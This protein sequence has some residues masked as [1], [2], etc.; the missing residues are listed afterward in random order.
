MNAWF[1]KK[2][3]TPFAA[4]LIA[5][6]CIAASVG[7]TF[8]ALRRPAVGAGEPTAQELYELAVQDAVF[9]DEEEILP[10]VEVVRD[11]DKVT[12]NEAGDRILLLSWH[13]YPDSYPAG[14]EVAFQW[15]EVWAFTDREIVRRYKEEKNSVTDWTLRLEQ[16]IG[17]PPEKGYTHFSAFWVDPADVIR[18]AYVTDITGQMKNTFDAEPSGDAFSKWYGEW[19]DGNIVWSYFDSAYPWTRL[20]YTYDWADNGTEYGLSEFLIL[21]NSK[22]TV[23]FTLSNED[24]L[25]WLGE[26]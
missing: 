26:Q 20:G 15:G 9:A 7:G 23:A 16:L 1:K 14:E 5:L 2:T 3:L 18:P 11:S 4:A 13:R 21:P 19:Y 17:L 6:A 8:L 24:F 22:A 12:W 25:A 10:L